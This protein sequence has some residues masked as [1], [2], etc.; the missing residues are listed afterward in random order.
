M[1]TYR[2]VKYWS[3]ILIEARAC[4][5]YIGDN[6]VIHFDNAK[7]GFFHCWGSISGETVGIVESID[8]EVELVDPAF[9]KFAYTDTTT[10]SINKA[11]EF[12]PDEEARQRVIDVIYNM[13]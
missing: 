1:R 6:E 9:I 12:I 3:G 13:K 11:L 8:G 4:F 10:E 7:I 2:K 5:R